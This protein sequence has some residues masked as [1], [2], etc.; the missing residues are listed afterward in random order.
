VQSR[1]NL[2]PISKVLAAARP[3][4]QV[5]TIGIDLMSDV[6]HAELVAVIDCDSGDIVRWT[7]KFYPTGRQEATLVQ[8]AD[9]GSHLLEIA[10]EKVLVLGCHDLNMFSERARAN[11]NP[12]G[13][14][15]QRCDEMRRAI[16]RFEPTVVLQHPHSTDSA[17][18]WR[19]PWAGLTR[20]HPSIRTYASGIGYFNCYGPPRRP[21][22]DVLVGTR[23]ESDVADVVVKSE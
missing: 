3:L 7:G 4:T 15:R 1:R 6:E 12:H 13:I 11:Q 17:N 2:R 20:D 10:G 19:V 22:R 23:S 16:V 14:R 8:V 9:I 5:L 18:I 21:L